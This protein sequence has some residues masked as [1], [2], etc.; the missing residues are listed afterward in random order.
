MSPSASA[1]EACIPS[2]EDLLVPCAWASSSA[3]SCSGTN[4]RP[5][6]CGDHCSLSSKPSS[7]YRPADADPG[8][9]LD[10]ADFGKTS[11]PARE[12]L[13]VLLPLVSAPA[14]PVM[15]S[16][17]K[18]ERPVATAAASSASSGA[19]THCPWA[20][21][22]RACREPTVEDAAGDAGAAAKLSS[23]S[24]SEAEFSRACCEGL[25]RPTCV[26]T[27]LAGVSV[28]SA[29]PFVSSAMPRP[30]IDSA[31]RADI[32]WAERPGAD[33]CGLGTSL[34]DIWGVPGACVP[35]AV[36]FGLPSP[37]R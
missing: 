8:R 29:G 4:W 19:A 12:D 35:L 11:D 1:C 31:A 10:A 25:S 27:A 17:S 22:S 13:A 3:P 23:A 33:A 16:T 14:T 6:S 21:L 18:F 32:F 24:R 9:A 30:A 36:D 2:W 7:S 34:D 28:T 26:V 5:D 20:G 37:F 15:S